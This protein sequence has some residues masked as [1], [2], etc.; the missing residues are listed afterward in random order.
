VAVP[1]EVHVG[2][3]LV[4][5]ARQRQAGAIVMGSRGLSG[6]RARLEG[7][8]SKDVLKHAPCPVLV[9]HESEDAG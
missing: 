6:L 4:D 8:T 3:A 9:V 1:D 7:S 5:L 2:D